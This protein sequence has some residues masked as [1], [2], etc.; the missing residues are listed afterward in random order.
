MEGERRGVDG[1][2]LDGHRGGDG[3]DPSVKRRA[4]RFVSWLPPSVIVPRGSRTLRH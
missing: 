3:T 4:A 2:E 1:G